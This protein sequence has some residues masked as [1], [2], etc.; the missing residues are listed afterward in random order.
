M[1]TIME[2]ASE[3]EATYK[4]LLQDIQDEKIDQAKARKLLTDRKTAFEEK[5]S[6]LSIKEVALNKQ[7]ASIE[8][9]FSKI[10]S[11]EQ[12]QAQYNEVLILTEEADKKLKLAINHEAEADLKT[13]R[14]LEREKAVTIR[15][16]TYKEKIEKEY[17]EKLKNLI[18]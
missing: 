16:S 1:S 14:V 10:R 8:A 9:K 12:I 7:A 5:E 11:D 6:D 17:Q 4:Q 2:L 15:E 3:M 18:K 13:E